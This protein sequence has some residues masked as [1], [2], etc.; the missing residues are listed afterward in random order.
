MEAKS[1]VKESDCGS[2]EDYKSNEGCQPVVNPNTVPT[3]ALEFAVISVSY[4][5]LDMHAGRKKINMTLQN[6][7]MGIQVSSRMML[8]SRMDLLAKVVLFATKRG[9]TLYLLCKNIFGEEAMDALSQCY[10]AVNLLHDQFGNYGL[11]GSGHITC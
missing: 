10:D 6:T 5:H 3:I 4:I 7:A 8:I 1:W 9:A 2:K 11:Q